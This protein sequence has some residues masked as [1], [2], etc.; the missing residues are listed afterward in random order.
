MVAVIAVITG[1]SVALT[2]SATAAQCHC[3]AGSGRTIERVADSVM[4]SGS[5]GRPERREPSAL[6]VLLS[7]CT[8][9]HGEV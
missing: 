7:T 9:R 8:N 1:Q 2:R 4:V 5:A 3:S 6:S